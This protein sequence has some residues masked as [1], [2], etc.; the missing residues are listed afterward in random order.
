MSKIKTKNKNS[1]PKSPKSLVARMLKQI[2]IGKYD[3]EDYVSDHILHD[4]YKSVRIID[5]FDQIKTHCFSTE[6]LAED[7]HYYLGMTITNNEQGGWIPVVIE[8][9]KQ[10][11]QWKIDNVLLTIELEENPEVKVLIHNEEACYV[12]ELIG[13]FEDIDEII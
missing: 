12:R 3:L 1:Y 2:R 7:N 6:N 4:K 9:E 13:L 10:N 5:F 8:L 11:L